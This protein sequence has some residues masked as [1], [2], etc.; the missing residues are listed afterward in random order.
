MKGT[1]K[2]ILTTLLL[3]VILIFG[4]NLVSAQFFDTAPANPPGFSCT[5]TSGTPPC[6]PGT[7]IGVNTTDNDL[8]IGENAVE[9]FN[10]TI[11]FNSTVTYNIT[12]INFSI[13]RGNITLNDTHAKSGIGGTLNG[14]AVANSTFGA[15]GVG[16][17]YNFSRWI[18]SNFT[19]VLNTRSGIAGGGDYF[20]RAGNMTGANGPWAGAAPGEH[21]RPLNISSFWFVVKAPSAMND[22]M[23]GLLRNTETP[24]NIVINIT[25]NVSTAFAT[26]FPANSTT[27]RLTLD[28]APPRIYLTTPVNNTWVNTKLVN[29]SFIATD[30]FLK[31]CTLWL[32]VGPSG[33]QKNLS[34]TVMPN[35]TAFGRDPNDGIKVGNDT[36]NNVT[37]KDLPDNSTG[38]RWSIGCYDIVHHFNVSFDNRTVKIDATKPSMTDLT[39]SLGTGVKKGALS[40]LKCD[41]SDISPDFINIDVTGED[42]VVKKC[43]DVTTCSVDYT[44]GAAGTQT[45]TCTAQDNAGNQNTKTLAVDVSSSADSTTTG[46]GGGGGATSSVTVNTATANQEVKYTPNSNEI[47]VSEVVFAADKPVSSAKLILK[48]LGQPS[49]GVPQP[50]VTVYKF[51]EVNKNNFGDAKVTKADITFTV[52]DIWLTQNG[53]VKDDIKL[54]KY[55]EGWKELPTTYLKLQ[56]GHH[57]YKA[58][59]GGFSLFAIASNKAAEQP[60]A[61]APTAEQPAA[62]APTAEQ[63]KT[64]ALP[65]VIV[66][67]VLVVI[68]GIVYFVLKKKNE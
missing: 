56:S 57:H 46:T 50:E 37:V 7:P 35:G 24:G 58:Q 23:I 14:S 10:F 22:T 45:V 33:T 28:T 4:A 29:F 39:S 49:T 1:I 54:L 40:T 27:V 12:S 65:F 17:A 34:T 67:V 36:L 19:S 21:W 20:C 2:N 48:S 11:W 32:D 51:F 30:N 9:I 53:V 42:A 26:A 5:S 6:Q 18:C 63:E 66:L 60:A 15:G 38:Y 3:L 8:V 64:S 43:E 68:V 31:N 41:I 44:F 52:A 13:E 62:E 25:T 47:G 61:E 55:E 59:A 16:G